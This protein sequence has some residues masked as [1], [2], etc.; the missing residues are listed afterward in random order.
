MP[1]QE[2]VSSSVKIAY[3]FKSNKELWVCDNYKELERRTRSILPENCP[4]EAS[5][6]DDT[7]KKLKTPI[8]LA[9]QAKVQIDSAKIAQARTQRKINFDKFLKMIDRRAGSDLVHTLDRKLLAQ[10]LTDVSM[11]PEISY[12]NGTLA[13]EGR[14]VIKNT[15][16]D[17][18]DEFSEPDLESQ[19]AKKM[20][21]LKRLT[22]DRQL[23]L[24]AKKYALDEL[25]LKDESYI[26]K[27]KTEEINARAFCAFIGA[28]AQSNPSCEIQE[29]F[30]NKQ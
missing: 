24:L 17:I 30:W 6:N 14:E 9:N 5:A 2:R 19:P 15:F 28:I 22:S 13:I 27:Y 4:Y 8:S 20:R 18:L 3:P 29:Y 1:D 26:N 12:D 11:A 16:S 23:N 7:S 21:Y 10:S 25:V